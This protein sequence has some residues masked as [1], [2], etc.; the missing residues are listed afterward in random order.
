[1]RNMQRLYGH[2]SPM[3][4]ELVPWAGAGAVALPVGLL[5]RDGGPGG[6]GERAD[7]ALE[8]KVFDRSTPYRVSA[9]RARIMRLRE[10]RLEVVAEVRVVAR[11]GH[12]DD[13][14][15][16]QGGLQGVAR[17]SSSVLEKRGGEPVSEAALAKGMSAGEP[18]RGSDTKLER[19]EGALT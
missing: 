5:R 2:L 12:G 14:V 9:A 19:T 10:V 6:G 15:W 4:E 18:S 11:V 17:M 7:H 13:E 1:M 3:G 8:G 16:R